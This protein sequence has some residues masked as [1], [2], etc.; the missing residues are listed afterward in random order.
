[1]QKLRVGGYLMLPRQQLATEHA[2]FN[3]FI[4]DL[5]KK[6]KDHLFDLGLDEPTVRPTG[7]WWHGY[8]TSCVTS[9]IDMAAAQTGVR[10][11]PAQDIL[12]INQAPL[13]IPIGNRKLVPDQLFA[14]NYGGKYR[15][16]MLEV[17]RGTEPKTSNAARKTYASSIELY[18]TM[19]E[20]NV[21]RTHYGL[22]ATTLILWVFSLPTN[23]QR[24]LEMVGKI[25]GP[26]KNLI[27]TQVMPNDRAA[28]ANVGSYYE[29]DWGRCQ[30]GPLLLSR[31]V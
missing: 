24:F 5:T 12:A 23:E 6:A 21:Y 26:A 9:S 18:R 30:N 11:V 17:D 25:G 28:W 2:G 7:H 1:M 14:L 27:C 13:A 22:K 19:I 15:A 4:Y 3:P 10:Y 16:F 8:M 20:Q 31:H 29:S